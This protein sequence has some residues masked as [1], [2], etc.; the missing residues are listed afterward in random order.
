MATAKRKVP[1]EDMTV[2]EFLAWAGSHERNQLV[3]GEVRALSPASTTHAL[4]QARLARLLDTHL[5]VPGNPCS[6]M[7]EPGIEVRFNAT[8]NVRVPDLA[9]SCVPNSAGQTTLPD[10]I[11]LVEII[12]PGNSRETWANVWAYTTIPTVR[13]ILIVQST[14]IEAELFR[15][16]DDGSWPKTSQKIGPDDLLRLTA[17]DF[18]APLRAVYAK[19]HL[20]MP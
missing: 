17:I 14:R 3:D 12:S 20:A 8:K 9:V 10:P 4:I 2:D 6:V 13:E 18:A 7:T 5:D 16:G 1:A 15:R 11:L 19:T